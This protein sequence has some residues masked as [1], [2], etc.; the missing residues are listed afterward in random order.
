ILRDLDLLVPMGALGLVYA[1]VSVTTVDRALA[2]SL[3]PRA[4]TPAR[5]I[6]AIKG[7][8][9]A[10]VPVTV[11][12]AP[13]IPA[14]NEPEME[15]ILATAAAAGATSAGWVL[16]RLPWEIK[17]LFEEWL[18]THRPDAAARVMA[19]VRDMRGGKAYEA[20]WSTRQRGRGVFA[21]LIAKRFKLATDR[22]GLGDPHL[23]LR[24]DLFKRP[25]LA[26][27]QLS[28]L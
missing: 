7:L 4:A 9:A 26:G 24:T 6:D 17:D 18:Q 25:V 22:L 15:R 14:L 13:I 1:A 21:T 23:E 10:G 3:E 16:L 2:R 19:R 27:G 8:S 28:L 20:C 11:M 12:V 5:R